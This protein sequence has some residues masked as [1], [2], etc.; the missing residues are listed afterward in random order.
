MARVIILCESPPGQGKCLVRGAYTQRKKVWAA[1][2]Q[3]VGGLQSTHA[4]ADDITGKEFPAKYPKLCDLLRRN[5]RALLLE[6]GSTYR[7]PGESARRFLLVEGE[8]NK[9]RDWDLDDEGRPRPCPLGGAED[10]EAAKEVTPTKAPAAPADAGGADV[11]AQAGP[12][13]EV[14]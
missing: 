8:L 12:A 9:L 1:I 13:A 10:G 5:G 14:R 7:E 6:P 11:G 3:S 2:E 4:L